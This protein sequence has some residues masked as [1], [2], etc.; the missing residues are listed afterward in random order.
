V[1]V[2]AD[3]V[4]SAVRR[5][6]L[7]DVEIIGAGVGGLGLFARSPLTPETLAALPDVLL[8]GFAIARDDVGG[9]LALGAYVPRRPVAEAV[10]D[11]APDVHV[12]PVS[13]YMMLSGGVPPGTEVPAPDRWTSDTPR[14]MH[15]RM[16]EVVADWHPAL[17]GLVERVELDTLFAF[18]FRRLDPTPPW[19][20][21]RVTLLGDAI[22]A[23]LPTLGQGANQALRDA[24]LL[25][26]QLA[27]TSRGEV[28]LLD[29]IAG[30][31]DAMRDYVYPIM[32]MSADHSRFGG[33]GLRRD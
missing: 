1:L 14:A 18:P 20:T 5:Q 28:G 2:G 23:M 10:A 24:G 4:G 3:G 30:Y 9:M 21:S 13:P 31:E 8:D 26:G 19:P 12:D 17:R 15:E 11:L 7:P 22:H 16:L 33:G 32:E 6:L 25:A 27:A 29:A